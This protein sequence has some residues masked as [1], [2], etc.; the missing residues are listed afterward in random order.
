MH[1]TRI[2]PTILMVIVL[3]LMPATE[4]AAKVVNVGT[5][6]YEVNTASPTKVY[7]GGMQW[8]VIGHNG[9]G[10]ASTSG[11]LTLLLANGQSYSPPISPTK[12]HDSNNVYS[13]S[14]LIGKMNDAYDSL[15]SR[16]K[17][18]I[19]ERTL[20]GGNVNFNVTGHDKNNI[21]GPNVDNAKFWPLGV[22]E[23][24]S[25]NVTTREFLTGWW[26]RSPG[27]ATNTAAQIYSNGSVSDHGSSVNIS[28]LFTVRPAFHLDLTSAL[29]A[30]AVTE[31]KS[32]T[33]V[34][35]GLIGASAPTGAIKYTFEDASSLRLT[36]VTPTAVNMRKITFNYTG[37][38]SGETLSAIFK[39]SNGN[40]LY[41]GKLATV[42][43]SENSATVTIPDGI[44]S[45]DTLLIFVEE[46]NGDNETD[47]ASAFMQI[48]LE[49]QLVAP[50]DLAGVACTTA[51]NNDGKI[52]G[53]STL[54]E[55]SADSGSTWTAC[56]ATVTTGLASGSY[57]VRFAGY[58]DNGKVYLADATTTVMVDAY[59]PPPNSSGSGGVSKN[60]GVSPTSVTF[61]KNTASADYYDI[62]VTLYPANY[63]LSAIRHGGYALQAE[64]DYTV[65][66]NTYIFKTSYL[67]TLSLGNR[68]LTFD[69]SDGTD[70]ALTVMVIDTTID[71]AIDPITD[72]IIDPTIDPTVTV[73]PP[74]EFPFTN[75][76]SSDWFYHDVYYIWENNLINN[77]EA[78]KFDPNANL[79]RGLLVTIIYHLEKDPHISGVIPFDD[80]VAGELFTE[81]VKWAAYYG[82]VEGYGNGRF[83]PNDNITREQMAATLMRYSNFKRV[84]HNVTDQWIIFADEADIDGY[85]IDAM[86][87]LHKLGVINGVGADA[88]GHTIVNP[89]GYTT[90]AEA[91]A[92]LHRFLKLIK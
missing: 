49:L 71:P 45:A 41:Y 29:F 74:G 2:L 10:V 9:S 70:P 19:A 87:T 63:A 66:G 78:D 6:Q 69:M 42:N 79:A 77:T 32:S 57:K 1:K 88:A 67:D 81:A 20:I 61:D 15:S 24:E 36:S 55:Y 52:T 14:T 58:V 84:N 56:T 75:V 65:S 62:S 3:T 76:K 21:A 60:A 92:M 11:T 17:G 91:A 12:F 53:T 50:S 38:T 44:D 33:N 40:I 26:L 16:D 4:L 73:P 13:S 82:I 30:S 8:V 48:P 25:V 51:A 28:S 86:Q 83:G 39:N 47:F 22:G 5:P 59:T 18:L 89:E 80:L 64:R 46:N 27:S 54:M 7:F 31:G 43:A 68:T 37:A 23:A 85:A 90:M 34:G 35:D 72:P